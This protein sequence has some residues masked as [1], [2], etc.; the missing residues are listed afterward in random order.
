MSVRQS[1]ARGKPS[2]NVS[3]GPF[4]LAK[5]LCPARLARIAAKAPEP[6]AIVVGDEADGNEDQCSGRIVIFLQ[7][8]VVPQGLWAVRLRHSALVDGL[9]P[10]TLDNGRMA[11]GQRGR[12][13]H[14]LSPPVPPT[15]WNPTRIPVQGACYF[16]MLNA[17]D[18][19]P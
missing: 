2:C 8:G 17:C 1:R 4:N 7:G 3:S 14:F 10:E 9:Q 12:S 5:G 11:F 13:A 18:G 15:P 16:T 6:G 19:W